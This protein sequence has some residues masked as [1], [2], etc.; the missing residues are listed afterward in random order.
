MGRRTYARRTGDMSTLIPG[1]KPEPTSQ[2]DY[3]AAEGL[4][5]APAVEIPIEPAGEAEKR[6]REWLM[7]AVGLTS[8]VT[9][10][11][12]A[13]SIWAMATR[14]DSGPATVAP[15]ATAAP[16]EQSAAAEQ[17]APTLADAK[18]VGFEPFERVDPTLPPVPAGVVKTFKVDVYQHVT[19]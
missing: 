1:S 17:P 5:D 16:A 14:E 12:I 18:G 13:V 9:V 19:Q 2:V 3:D 6:R 15:A 10:L 8:L 7:V 4:T 11:A